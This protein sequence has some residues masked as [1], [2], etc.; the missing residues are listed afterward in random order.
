LNIEWADIESWKEAKKCLLLQMENYFLAVG[1]DPFLY[2]YIDEY[3]PKSQQEHFDWRINPIL[4]DVFLGFL[5]RNL[6]LVDINKKLL[7]DTQLTD[8]MFEDQDHS[9]QAR[10][11]INDF[12]GK[13]VISIE[14]YDSLLEW[15][16]EVGY[17]KEHGGENLSYKEYTE[18]FKK[19]LG[20]NF[21]EDI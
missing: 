12:N 1:P 5:T 18:F 17:F 19:N 8:L 10:F 2:S 7:E 11:K 13:D 6:F 9:F 14:D 4:R 15:K 21:V 16:Y 3:L 20:S